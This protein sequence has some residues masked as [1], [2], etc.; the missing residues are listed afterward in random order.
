MSLKLYMEKDSYM[1]LITFG[2]KSKHG[3][4]I[5]RCLGSVSLQPY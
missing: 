5:F 1:A 4:R 3:A 2:L